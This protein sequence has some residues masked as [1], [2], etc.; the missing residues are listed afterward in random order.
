MSDF[1]IF[2]TD[3]ISSEGEELIE[4]F[5]DEKSINFEREKKIVNLED[6]Y[7]DY[8]VADFYLPSYKVYIEFLGKWDNEENKQKYNKKKQ[9]YAKNK[10]PCLYL[11]P[12]N[13]GILEYIFY[14]RLKK[15]LQEHKELNYQLF[16]LNF[17]MLWE[18]Y[19]LILIILII[20]IYSIKELIPR[21]FLSIIFLIILAHGVKFTFLR[22]IRQ[23][24]R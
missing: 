12:D 10:I 20:F 3:F 8:R 19:A 24:H 1:F 17:R 15:V 2:M 6:D 21:I 7:A 5:L 18:K 13:L 16:K 11:Y 23:T 14:R 9:I 4:E 22:K